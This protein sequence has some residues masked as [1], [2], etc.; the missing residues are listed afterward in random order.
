MLDAGSTVYELA[1]LLG[2]RFHM[3]TVLTHSLEVMK[4]LGEK[5]NIRVVLAGG[6]YL[7]AS[8]FGYGAPDSCSKML[9]CACG[10][11]PELRYQ[12]SYAGVDRHA[13]GLFGN[14]RP[15]LYPGGQF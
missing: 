6:F 14:S 2:E 9:Y 1:A 3:L 12:R 13:E 7:P 4:I 11:L 10:D 8:G 5:E 15:G